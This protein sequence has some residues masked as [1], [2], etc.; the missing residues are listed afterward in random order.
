MAG[1]FDGP[2]I[3]R[4]LL[5]EKFFETMSGVEKEGG[6]CFSLWLCLISWRMGS[7]QIMCRPC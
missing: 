7:R 5:D 3:R 4:L 6:I 1:V 2:Q